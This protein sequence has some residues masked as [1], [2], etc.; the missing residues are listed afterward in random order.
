MSQK[1]VLELDLMQSNHCV[2]R[3]LLLSNRMINRR[4]FLNFFTIKF[5]DQNNFEQS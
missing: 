3:M 1:L 4:I 5:A 2:I